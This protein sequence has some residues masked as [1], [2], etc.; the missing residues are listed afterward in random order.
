MLDYT[1]TSCCCCCLLYHNF[2]SAF[3]TAVA[4][5]NYNSTAGISPHDHD[6]DDDHHHQYPSPITK[7]NTAA[8]GSIYTGNTTTTATTTSSPRWIHRKGKAYLYLARTCKD[9]HTHARVYA[10]TCMQA[11]QRSHPFSVFLC[12]IHANPLHAYTHAH[13]STSTGG[14]AFPYFDNN[15]NHLQ[16]Q[17]GYYQYGASSWSSS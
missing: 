8:T 9:T 2:Q 16:F 4:S 14:S 3:E 10:S 1:T 12:A 11:T 7:P 6:T 15:N 17:Q 5:T 13:A